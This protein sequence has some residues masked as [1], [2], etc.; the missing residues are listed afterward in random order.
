[1][2]VGAQSTQLQISRD[3]Q[4]HWYRNGERVNGVDD[5]VDIDLSVS[6]ATNTLPIRRLAL[7]IGES[8]AVDA[9]WVRFPELTI[10]RLDQTYTRLD[11]R[12][13]RYQSGRGTFTAEIEVDDHG[14][15]VRYSNLWE[16]MA[17]I[18][19]DI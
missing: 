9:V 13:Y 15:V 6:P 1:V 16:R 5:L 10:E 2:I 4:N 17:A 8:H 19:H 3:E 11:A 7:Q 18:D 14:V 12:R